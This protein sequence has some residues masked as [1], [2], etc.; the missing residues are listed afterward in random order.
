MLIVSFIFARGGSKGIKNKNLLKFKKTSLLGNSILQSRKSHL[1]K[2][3]FVS[4]DSKK[5]ANEAKKNKAEVP[6]VRPKRLASSHSPEIYSWR[7]AVDF[8]DKELN[9][10]PDYIVSLPSTAPL[11]SLVDINQCIKKAVKNN[12]DLVSCITPS[13][14]NPYFNILEK[15][16]GKFKIA[17]KKKKNF[18]RRQDAPKCFD[19]TTACYVFKPSYIKKTLDLYS[20][21]VGFVIIPKERSIDIDD[22]WDYKIANLFAK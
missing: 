3:T 22:I 15:N 10:R 2:R 1:I 16:K 6:F 9:L 19:L 13:Y 5:V 14:R 12:L 8:L 18:F 11:R 20:G 4:T 7:H 17:S 21:N